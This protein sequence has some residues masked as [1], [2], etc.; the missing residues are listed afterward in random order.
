M[1]VLCRDLEATCSFLTG[2]GI[3]QV[4]AAGARLVV[5]PEEANGVVLE[6]AEG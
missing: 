6:F 3:P 1:T 4:D 2:H 5:P